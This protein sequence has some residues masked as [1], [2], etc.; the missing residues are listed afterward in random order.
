MFIDHR[1]LWICN[2][3]IKKHSYFYYYIVSFY[4]IDMISK[5]VY[6]NP[7][8]LEAFPRENV[9]KSGQWTVAFK[10]AIKL[11][12]SE[13]KKLCFPFNVC[14]KNHKS[15]HIYVYYRF[16]WN[17]RKYTG[18]RKTIFFT[19]FWNFFVFHSIITFSQFQSTICL[20]N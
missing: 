1:I 6:T 20:L 15:A 16:V 19:D 18:R 12:K 11:F 2:K 14:L 13:A 3:T 5:L 17:S 9:S 7:L 4:Q 8:K 10:R